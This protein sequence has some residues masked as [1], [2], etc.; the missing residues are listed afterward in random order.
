MDKGIT[1]LRKGVLTGLRYDVIT[2]FVL[3]ALMALPQVMMAQDD[4]APVVAD[5]APADPE[6]E[7]IIVGGNIYGGGN[8]G[9]VNGNTTVNVMAGDLNMV[10]GGA[11]MANVGGRSFVNIDGEH[12]TEFKYAVINYVFGGNDIAGTVGTSRYLPAALKDTTVNKIDNTWNSFVRVSTKMVNYTDDEATAYNTEHELREGDEGYKTTNDQKNAKDIYIGQLFAGGNGDYFYKNVTTGTGANAKTTHYIYLSESD[13]KKDVNSYIASNETGFNRPE[14]DKTYLEIEGGSIVY[15][16]GGGNNATVREK[17]VIHLDNPSKVVNHIID[18]RLIAC[19]IDTTINTTHVNESDPAVGELLTYERFRYAMGINTGFSKPSSDE[20]QIGRLFGGNNKAEMNIR[21]TW[22]LQSG[23]V[24][25]LYSGGN[26]GAMTHREGLLL[27]I[28][29]S[30]TIVVDNLY[31][32][33]RMADVHPLQSGTLS[34]DDDDVAAN[35]AVD[36]DLDDIMLHD[37]NGNLLSQYPTGLAARVLIEGGDINNVYGGN[38]VTGHVVGGNA[39]GVHT[40]IRGDIYG[41]GNGAYPYT[42]NVELKDHDI[43][44]DLYYSPK[45][46]LKLSSSSFTGILSAEALN[47][48]RPDAEQV[49]IR[50]LGK[51]N[52]PTIIRGSVF[53][54]GNC[55]TISGREGLDDPLAQLKIGSYVI[56]DK[57][58]MGNNGEGMIEK[59]ILETYASSINNDEH[60]FSQM[61]LTYKNQMDTYMEGVAMS[62]KPSSD[63]SVTFDN[64]PTAPNDPLKT[65]QP[66]TTQIGSFFCGGNVGSM[67]F[68]GLQTWNIIAPVILYEKFVGGCNNADVP[69]KYL[70]EEHKTGQLNAAYEGGI[71]GTEGEENYRDDDNKIKDRLHINFNGIR[72][73]P[74]R[75]NDDK[76]ALVWNTAKWDDYCQIESGT[77]LN[78]GD[79]YYTYD[80]TTKQYTK[81]KATAAITVPENGN[82]YEPY[83]GFTPIGTTETEYDD[84]RRL[85]GGNIYGGCYN[86]GHVNGN[87]VINID[88]DLIDRSKVFADISNYN[89]TTDVYTINPSKRNSGVILD[90]QAF[91]V[92]TVAMTVFGAGSGKKTEI[93]GSTNVNLNNGYTFQIFGGGE[94]GY[95]GQGKSYHMENDQ[96]V[97]DYDNE[98]YIVR[99]YNDL[100]D[101]A[102][103]STVNLNGV[104]AGY[105]EEETG[106][107]LPEAEYLYGGGNEGDVCGNSYVYLGN[108]RIYDAFGGASDADVYGHTEVYIGKNR[109]GERGFPWV[110]DI[111]YGGNDYGGNIRGAY[112]QGFDFTSRVRN[113]AT[114]KSMIHGY[115]PENPDAIPGVLKAPAAYVEYLEGRVDTIFGGGYGQ[116]DYT[117]PMYAYED[118]DDDGNP[119]MLQPEAPYLSSSFVNIRPTANSKNFIN[120]VFGAGT[121]YPDYRDGDK[122]Q[123]RSYVLIDIP[124]ESVD[125]YR[126]MDIF[127]G[128]SWN[129]LGMRKTVLPTAEVAEVAEPGAGA[130]EEE[131]TAYNNYTKYLKY[132]EDLDSIS[133]VVDLLRG[134][135]G[136]AYGG[137]YNEG[138]TR[139]TVVNVPYGSTIDIGSIFGGAYGNVTLDPCDV[140]EANVNFHSPTAWLTYN[141]ERTETIIENGQQKEITVGND[142]LQGAI[143]GG[144]N[145]QRRT[146]Y[147]KV[148]IDVPVNEYHY[149]YGTSKASVYGAGRGNLTWAE[150][151]EVNLLEKPEDVSG[152]YTKPDGTTA[153]YTG[154]EVWEVY[155]GGQD[156]LIINAEG[157]QKYINK[158]A[159]AQGLGDLD[160]PDQM[161]HWKVGWHLGGG[162]DKENEVNAAFT[163]AET[164]S[165]STFYVTNKYTNLDNP[166]V[167]PRAEFG[168]KKFNTNVIINKG[169]YVGNYAYGGG[170]GHNNI[171]QSGNVYGTTYIALL[172]GT[173]SKDIYAAGSSGTVFDLFGVG[174]YD[175][176]NNPHGF[177]AS[178][179]AYVEGGTCRNVYGGGWEGNVGRHTG[180]TKDPNS[181]EGDIPGE[182]HVVIG[183][184]PASETRRSDVLDYYRGKP[185]IQRNAYAGGEGGSV[186]GTANITVNNGYIGYVHLEANQK[187]DAQGY[188]VSADESEGLEVR[189]EEKINDETNWKEGV[190]YGNQSLK[191]C[192]NVFGSGYD[193]LTSVDISHVTLY[194]GLI[195]N[196]VF[197][198]GEIATVGRGTHASADAPTVS[199]HKAGQTNVY[200][201]GGHV[202]HNVY[203]GGK[204]YNPLGFGGG[205]NKYTDGYVFG[206]TRVNIYGGEIGTETGVREATEL[207]KVGNVFGGGDAGFVYS[208]FEIQNGNDTILAVGKKSGQRLDD[209]EDGYYYK[210][211]NNDTEDDFIDDNGIVLATNAE[212]HLTEDCKVLIEPHCKVK[213][214]IT[215]NGISYKTGDFV[216]TSV[217]NTLKDKDEDSEI[218]EYLDDT[219]IIINNAVFAGGNIAS[220]EQMYANILTVFGNATASI[221]DV[222]H[223]DLITLGTGKVG[224]LYGDGNLTLVDGYRELNITNYGTD[225]YYIKKK[226]LSQIDISVYDELSPREKDY[227]EV[228]YRCVA[229]SGCT[230]NEHTTYIQGS[231]L[232]E[233]ELLTR[234]AGNTTIITV[235]GINPAYWQ[236]VAS[237]TNYSGRLLNTIQR[238]DFCGIFGSRMIMKG[239]KDRVPQE[240]DDND[241]TIN[242]VR[243]VSLNKKNSTISGDDEPSHGNY[244]GIYSTVNYLG[245][246]TSDLDFGDDG[247]QTSWTQHGDI[248]HTNN[249]R[250]DYYK[251]AANDKAYGVAT[252]YDWKKQYWNDQ[253]RNN[254]LSHNQVALASGVSLE[255]LTE[256]SR[257]KTYDLKDWGII[258]GVV[259]LDLINVATGIGGGYV[260]AKNIHGERKATGKKQTILT[261]LNK[262]GDVR[263]ATKKSWDYIETNKYTSI[264]TQHEWQTS[265][266]F[267][268]NTQTIIDDCYNKKNHYLMSDDER[269]AAHYWYIKGSV[270]VYDQVISAYTGAPN[271]YSEKVDIPLT[272]TSASHGQIKLIDV[273]PNLYA[274]YS[275]YTDETHNTKLTAES[276]IVINDVTYNLNDPISYWDWSNLS[277]SEQKLFCEETYTNCVACKIDGGTLYPAGTYVMT[278]DEF[279]DF[280]N[281]HTYT[282]AEGHAILDNLYKEAD[283]DYVFRQSNNVSH[284]NGYILTYE[285]NNPSVWDKWFTEKSDS[286]HDSSK[287]KEKNQT[288]GTGYEAAPTYHPTAEGLY[289]QMEY[290]LSDIIKE[291]IFETYEGYVVNDNGTTT[292]NANNGL[293]TKYADVIEAIV[294]LNPEKDQATFERAY[295][296]TEYVETENKEKLDQHLQKGA[297]LAKS[298]YDDDKWAALSGKVAPAY[299][300][301]TT[302]ALSETEFIYPGDLLTLSQKTEYLALFEEGTDEYRLINE[303][304]VPAY[305]CT[306][307]GYYGGDYYQT[308]SNYPAFETLNAMSGT[309]FDAFKDGFNYDALDLLIDPNFG[310]ADGEKYQYDG[311]PNF[312]PQTASQAERDKMIYSLK[313]SVDYSATYNGDNLEV[314][315]QSVTVTHKNATEESSGVTTLVEGDL[316]DRENYEKLINEQYHYAAITVPANGGTI[317]VVNNSFYY[318]EQ[319]AAGKVISADVYNSLPNNSTQNLQNNVTKLT[320]TS[321]EGGKTYYYCRDQYT[322]DA[323]NGRPVKSI[324]IT[325]Q[326]GLYLFNDDTFAKGETVPV[327]V[328]ISGDD[329]IESE[330]SDPT[331]YY[332]Y[333]HLINQQKN[334]T[335]H[336]VSPVETSTLYVSRNSDLRD[337]SKEKI[338]TVIYQYDYEESEQE[339]EQGS[340]TITPYSE[341]HVVNIHIRFQGGEPYVAEIDTPGIV[342]P[343]TSVVPG[344]PSVVAGGYEIMSRGWEVYENEDY[345]KSHTNGIEYVPST[346]PLYWYQ[347]GYYISYYAKTYLG[348]FFSNSVPLSVANYHRMDD[349]LYYKT[350]GE[351]NNAVT[352]VETDNHYMYLDKA[353]K[354]NKRDPKV[355]IQDANE[356][357]KFAEFYNETRTKDELSH[358]V[359]GQ[360]IDFIIDGNVN[361]SEAWTSLGDATK[362]DG[363]YTNC[364]EGTIHGD[365]YTIIGLDNTLFGSLCGDVYNLGVHGSF[366]GAGIAET[367]SGYVENTWIGTSSKNAK[368]SKPVFGS[369][370]RNADDVAAKGKIQIVNSYYMEDDD[371]TAKYENHAANSEYGTTIRKPV[372]AFYNGEVAYDLNSFYLNKRY[373]DKQTLGENA[374][375]AYPYLE[376]DADGKLP[377]IAAEGYYP[378]DKADYAKYVDLG[379]V[380]QRYGDG[381]YRYAGGTIPTSKDPR[382]RTIEV[383]KTETTTDS[384]NQEVTTTT[385]TTQNIY[386]PIWPDDYLFFGQSL[387]FGYDD[388][389]RAHQNVP[390][391]FS[392]TNRVYRAPAYYRNSTMDVVHFNPDA[393]LAAYENPEQVAADATQHVAY[394]GMTAVDFA[395][396]NDIDINQ[397]YVQGLKNDQ[398]FPPLLD[399]DGL[400]SIMNADETRNLVVY[401]PAETASSGYANQATYNVLSDYF[402][403]PSYEAHSDEFSSSGA[404]DDSHTYKRVAPVATE[405]VHGHLVQNDFT[406]QTDHMLVDKN[407]FNAPMGYQ[408]ADNYRMWYQRKPDSYASISWSDDTTPVRST[409][410]WEGVSIPFEAELVTTDQK[411]EITH[412]YRK[413]TSGSYEKDYNSGHE[414]WLRGFENVGAKT[415][416]VVEASFIA[417]LKTSTTTKVDSN[418]FLWDYYY[419]HNNTDDDERGRDKNVDDRYQREYYKNDNR[420]Y[421]GYPRLAA[422]TPYIIGFP[423]VQFYEFDLSGEFSASTALAPIPVPLIKQTVTFV[424]KPGISIGVSDSE[425]IAPSAGVT[426]GA[427]TFKPSYLNA[428]EVETGKHAFP[429]NT[430]GNSFVEGANANTV[431]AFRPYFTAAATQQSGGGAPRRIIISGD[432]DT[433]LKPDIVEHNGI[434]DGGLKIYAENGVIVVESTRRDNTDVR[435][436]TTSGINLATFTIEPGQIVRTPVSMT[437]VYLVNR[438]KILVQKR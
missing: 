220:K 219:G 306:A 29:E 170:L 198:G 199:I 403:D 28:P 215:I 384:N 404:Y 17:T 20:F 268:H 86:S 267:V 347:D 80:T 214:D 165:T 397:P 79:E 93:W 400:T 381:D 361:Y 271:A 437:G 147:A 193:D 217:L 239:A 57:V 4:P 410:G 195:R 130:S 194:D 158:F 380:E 379:Y 127:G 2:G 201:Y 348:K 389:N 396:H 183:L 78:V 7:P 139:R 171:E 74:K 141:P 436:T 330:G 128:G 427:Y 415:D 349:V 61:D 241:Y 309:D 168:N 132:L 19:G 320:F 55:A 250:T 388:A 401:A 22:S 150:Y 238:A 315:G 353:V 333:D 321:A 192:G 316:L 374:R 197:G 209:D 204:G 58:F 177:T 200:M 406:A 225:Y 289:G 159:S 16:Y 223:R 435:I 15:A 137:S 438:T 124:Q 342:L 118:E 68:P 369:P 386:P 373:Y 255:L 104:N 344:A 310:G 340:S 160:D 313:K 205:H 329:Y 148:N 136:V 95:V 174:A 305:Y 297:K 302:I 432:D 382:E 117:D 14:L 265:G 129:G 346:D 211:L 206:Q 196:C 411:G 421:A 230:D 53:I 418:T 354:E 248:R 144:N 42:D 43:Y 112:E 125:N 40:S 190:W 116:Y 429:L 63:H 284:D 385:T 52:N 317:Y 166:L 81:Q 70:D 76:T 335:I 277:K 364:F 278:K 419:S 36:V 288:G 142:R 140:Y 285:M 48:F 162:Y 227:Y 126:D 360:S 359:N 275:S 260:Y 1:L 266:N 131:I 9:V 120:A 189:Y 299:V 327:G 25:N 433:S 45:D 339:S 65:Y 210:H 233:D 115:D 23:L 251:T 213:S 291:N 73:E 326:D 26:K 312:N 98:G 351:G 258:T 188:I 236:K 88:G 34:T 39:V 8:K 123:D 119:I 12:A 290:G 281:N 328:I 276:Q 286:D 269:V 33:C 356:L 50:L 414:Y 75:W 307:A 371:A 240:T 231:T 109:S 157:I 24:R 182:T 218:W 363:K 405:N 272:I 46:I 422:A 167:T 282:D 355:Y 82:Y 274:L 96:E 235:D 296:T 172:G 295:I 357:K 135:V 252:F 138:L 32:G 367:G 301:D 85:L 56:A 378:K 11:R 424:S 69:V 391:H 66:Y 122:S 365:G 151:T 300:C 362:V 420:R 287:A 207:G 393:V 332:G 423:G 21:P 145:H 334:F 245:A 428:P 337:L 108:G 153:T 264:T 49:S 413:D 106:L 417:P 152:E 366:T 121:G 338:I 331:Y 430:D 358:V 243:E 402:I 416:N 244:F 394:P 228:K 3:M 259:E 375:V 179:T 72:V 173:V 89:E 341:R 155:G 434:M 246:L 191:D 376:Y 256:K 279:D 350:T 60:D 161:K 399:D 283:T 37:E 146:L 234:F 212:K 222:Y 395:G 180:T 186:I 370:V 10:F 324:D 44:G 67:T 176:T 237:M 293:R 387:T 249:T 390:S 84:D 99:D 431:A 30:S 368:T 392:S 261:D 92:T 35:R 102:Y 164:L 114:D 308:S 154:A 352:T 143:Y 409:T 242:R 407:D 273:K 64:D 298:Q 105:S 263:A 41:G 229:E 304:I 184:R 175:E 181:T 254:G 294:E 318:T 412:F 18:D 372:Q 94:Q 292:G 107:P 110:R 303:K 38:D 257:G 221:H 319:Y 262:P 425:T 163:D 208:A 185:A 149:K 314:L 377:K 169:A 13:Y 113:Y 47:E 133:A 216:P 71:L 224:G 325:N 6:P 270:Y 280:G 97:Y 311:Y 62:L 343:G 83:D 27:E 345:A 101:I 232:L 87:V 202:L 187:Q 408:F 156:G 203:G 383:T 426:K 247:T 253:R 134:K 226:N 178:T 100:Y 59:S 398:W 323:T 54:G 91:D 103:S 51:P 322:I 111:V 5:P 336:G 77:T 31:G 90:R